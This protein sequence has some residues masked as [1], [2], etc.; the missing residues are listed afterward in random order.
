MTFKYLVWVK[1]EREIAMPVL[2]AGNQLALPSTVRFTLVLW[3][4]LCTW[5]QVIKVLVLA[6]E[7]CNF[8]IVA[9][10]FILSEPLISQQWTRNGRVSNSEFPFNSSM[11]YDHID[12][13]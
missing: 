8:V 12:D 3:K 13:M 10:L 2:W 7:I 6:L 1:E 4:E 9:I 11:Y 5:S